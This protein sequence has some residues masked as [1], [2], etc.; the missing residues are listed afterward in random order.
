VAQ[1]SEKQEHNRRTGE[2]HVSYS[3]KERAKR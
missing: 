3:C 1:Q 2:S